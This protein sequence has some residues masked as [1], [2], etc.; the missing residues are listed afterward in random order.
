LYGWYLTAP[1]VLSP[2]SARK[3]P[4]PNIGIELPSFKVTLVVLSG[5]A[6]QVGC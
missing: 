1:Y 4:S 3:T 2:G 6:V 5:R